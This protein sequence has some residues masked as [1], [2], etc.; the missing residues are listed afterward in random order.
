MRTALLA[1]L[2]ALVAGPLFGCKA[3]QS[4]VQ[5]AKAALDKL[6][7]DELAAYVHD[8]ALELTSH[9]IKFA[10]SRSPNSA[11]TI[12]ND[13]TIADQTLRAVVIPMFK[14]A[15]LGTVASGALGVAQAQLSAKLQGSSLDTLILVAKS[16][17]TQV[18]L[19]KNPDDKLSPRLQKALAAFFTGMAEGDE[20]ELSIPGPTPTPAPSSPGPAPTPPPK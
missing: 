2:L 18:T 10:M 9:G 16:I 1:T 14:D 15:P 20:K 17:L 6:S 3:I 5:A 19:P 8:G 11:A 4:E 13:G 7:D 12:K